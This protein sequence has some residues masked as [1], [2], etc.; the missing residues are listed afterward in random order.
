MPVF[1]FMYV[2]V[3]VGPVGRVRPNPFQPRHPT[4]SGNNETIGLVSGIL[5]SRKNKE[6]ANLRPDL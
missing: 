2:E 5:L 1:L 6:K 4:K 3:P